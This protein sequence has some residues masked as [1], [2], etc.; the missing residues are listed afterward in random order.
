MEIPAKILNQ[1]WKEK[2]QR[3]YPNGPVPKRI[4]LSVFREFRKASNYQNP[5]RY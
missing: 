4:C 5:Y 2:A 3:R 1:F